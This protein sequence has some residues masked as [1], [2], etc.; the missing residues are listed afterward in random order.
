[1][2][3]LIHVLLGG[4]IGEYYH[5]VL[6][7]V[8]ISLLS[9]F[10]LDII[11][12]WDGGDFDRKFFN[13]TGMF[14]SGKISVFINIL[15]VIICIFLMSFLYKEFHSKLMLAGAFAGMIPDL[16]KLGYLTKLRKNRHFINY[17]KFHS[18][19]QKDVNWRIGLIT[20]IIIT[21]FLIILLF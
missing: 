8:L 7:I 12:H 20:Q 13:K 18:R 4:L 11:P 16:A 1:M 10:I 9:H 5:S 19:I 3:I 2:F 6:L 15:D 17:L 21:V 14:F